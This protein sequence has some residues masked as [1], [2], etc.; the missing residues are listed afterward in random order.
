MVGTVSSPV[1]ERIRLAN[2]AGN[3]CGCQ[4]VDNPGTSEN[5]QIRQLLRGK[6][7]FGVTIRP[8]RNEKESKLVERKLGCRSDVRE[9]AEQVWCWH[10]A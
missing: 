5:S 6:L 10:G 1:V 7:L 9:F 8:V 3:L 2:S 4:C